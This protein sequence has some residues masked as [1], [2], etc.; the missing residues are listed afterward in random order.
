MGRRGHGADHAPDAPP[1]QPQ[2]WTRGHAGG[3]VK[4]LG[5]KR[6]I[7]LGEGLR[8]DHT[9]GHVD[10]LARF[11]APGGVIAMAQ[12]GRTI[13]TRRRVRLRRRSKPRAS[14]RRLDVVRLPGRGPTNPIGGTRRPRNELH[15]ANGVVVVPTY[16]SPRRTPPRSPSRAVPG[17]ARSAL[18][19]SACWMTGGG[20]FHC[21]TQQEPV[22][23]TRHDHRRR[24]P[25]LLRAGH[26]REYR[27]DRALVR[28]AARQGAQV[29]LPSEL[30]RA[31]TF[32]RGRSRNGS[33][34]RSPRVSI[35]ACSR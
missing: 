3:L 28:E 26:G 31:S 32:A 8:N 24:H 9:D 19:P 10:N 5:A 16:G 23:M 22:L 20:A 13:P 35:L 4:A 2:G 25:G 14:G 34:P 17:P 29:I 18:P 21:I 30:F 1:P 27:G 15:I 7:W 33:R 6:V 11:V 12:A